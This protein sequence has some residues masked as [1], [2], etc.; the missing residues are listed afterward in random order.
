MDNFLIF[1]SKKVLTFEKRARYNRGNSTNRKSYYN[2]YY[3]EEH[4]AKHNLNQQPTIVAKVQYS[5]DGNI[6]IVRT[7]GLEALSQTTL[8]HIK[9]A[10]G[11]GKKEFMA[12]PR[13]F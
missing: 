11:L 13:E 3:K 6:N 7:C 9:A 2:N 10:L 5:N 1:C 12:I 4:Y 8:R